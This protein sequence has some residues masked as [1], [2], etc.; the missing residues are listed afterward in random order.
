M[1]VLPSMLFQRRTVMELLRELEDGK[2]SVEA[3]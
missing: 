1:H 3:R 2:R